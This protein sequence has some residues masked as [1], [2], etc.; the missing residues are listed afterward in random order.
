M[1]SGNIY[2]DLRIG[3]Q[4]SSDTKP[5]LLLFDY[6]EDKIIAMLNFNERHEIIFWNRY[7][8]PDDARITTTCYSSSGKRKKE[9]KN[10]SAFG[11]LSHFSY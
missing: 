3:I 5:R 4:L 9:E 8:N 11:T 1:F 10:R 7:L 2:Q 6:D